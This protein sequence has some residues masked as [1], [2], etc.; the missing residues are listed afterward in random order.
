[1][2]R[3]DVIRGVVAATLLGIGVALAAP[4][5]AAAAGELEVSKDGVTY[6]SSLAA[7]LFSSPV[8]VPGQ[9]VS[10]VFYVRNASA[11]AAYLRVTL[12]S[13]SAS[14]SVFASG[15]T[16]TTTAPGYTTTSRSIDSASSCRELMS[17]PEILPGGTLAVT[18]TLTL[19]DLGGT[20]AQNATADIASGVTLTQA[21]GQSRSGCDAPAVVVPVVTTPRTATTEEPSAT[22]TPTPTPTP[23]PAE[24]GNPIES[25]PAF[26][27]TVASDGSLVLYSS[28]AVAAGAAAYFF[29][30]V[31]RRR[32]REL[33]EGVLR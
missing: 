24:G 28:L 4:E 1:M 18:T 12:D 5:S 7:P 6:G 22:P 11:D 32:R 29:L 3:I 13:S 31:L 33:V 8:L 26:F 15:L 25:F 30:P 14:S 19:G 27:N 2:R 10:T 21:V 20:T 16:L 9:S 17:G 23:Q